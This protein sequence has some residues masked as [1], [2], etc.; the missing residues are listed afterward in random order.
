MDEFCDANM[1]IG[2]KVCVVYSGGTMLGW[3]QTWQEADYIC[4]KK[5]LLQWEMKKRTRVAETVP[6]MISSVHT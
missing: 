4:E 1:A 6:Q 2:E 3:C 5:P